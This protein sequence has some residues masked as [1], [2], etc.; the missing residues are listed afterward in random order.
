MIRAKKPAMST[1]QAMTVPAELKAN[2][3]ER[4]FVILLFP[5]LF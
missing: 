3:I 2:L 4:G 1:K 5:L